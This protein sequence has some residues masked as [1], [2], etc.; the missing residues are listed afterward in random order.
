MFPPI[1]F[2]FLKLMLHL[3]S[4]EEYELGPYMVTYIKTIIQMIQL[5]CPQGS[6]HMSRGENSYN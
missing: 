1:N 5:I 6:L 4:T 2:F 3:F